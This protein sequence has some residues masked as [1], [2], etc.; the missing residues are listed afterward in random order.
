[1]PPPSLNL[2]DQLAA[3]ILVAG[4]YHDLVKREDVVQWAD[5]EIGRRD[6]VPTWLIDVSLSQR[7]LTLDLISR[8]NEV[9]GAVESISVCRGIYSLLPFPL[10]GYTYDHYGT[11][12]KGLYRL[13]YDILE[14]D[15]TIPLLTSA[16]I[17]ADN[18]GWVR[19]GNPGRIGDRMVRMGRNEVVQRFLDFIDEQRD[20]RVPEWLSPVRYVLPNVSTDY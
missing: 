10:T 19:D 20:R 17:A 2:D 12:A 6:E 8:L 15:W 13:T 7:L 1:M 14:G 3:A 5:A 16:D 18:F 4:L 11:L 9:A